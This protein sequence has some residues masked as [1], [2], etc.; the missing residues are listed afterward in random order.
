MT[1]VRTVLGDIAPETLGPTDAHEHFF[2]KS[3]IQ[4]GDEYSDVAKAIE[5]A[6]ALADAGASAVVDWT[7]LGLGHNLEGLGRIAQQTGLHVVGSTGVHRDAHYA[8]DDP[9]RGLSAE[10]L[11]DRFTADLTRDMTAAGAIK[12]GASYHHI[13]QFEQRV[14]EA[15]AIAHKRTGAPL[16]VHTEMGTFGRGIVEHLERFDVVP[17]AVILAHLDRNPDPG[18]HSETGQTGAW[19]QLDGPGRTKYWPDS[20]ILSLISALADSGLADRLLLGGDTGRRTTMRAY[21]GGPG[22]DYL[23]ARF[24]P[25]L[26]RELGHELSYQV[27]VENPASAFAFRSAVTMA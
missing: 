1:F 17:S 25:R 22:L 4:P 2:F 5:E 15:A 13:S 9:L 16:C 19:L 8:A 21:G 3:P 14:F 24:K 18:E 7:P 12:I 10:R 20:T 11:A 26:E 23:F 6:D 27:F